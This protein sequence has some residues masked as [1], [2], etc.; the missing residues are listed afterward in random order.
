MSPS[1]RA[2]K[3]AAASSGAP[4]GAYS[5]A[6]PKDGAAGN[7]GQAGAERLIAPGGTGVRTADGTQSSPPR[8]AGGAVAPSWCTTSPRHIGG[9]AGGCIMMDDAPERLAAGAVTAG[10]ATAVLR[11]AAAAAH[12]APAAAASPPQDSGS[13]TGDCA[14]RDGSAGTVLCQS[15]G[16]AALAPAGRGVAAVAATADG[17]RFEMAEAANLHTYALCRVCGVTQG[18]AGAG[19]EAE[20]PRC[21]PTLRPIPTAGS[22]QV[23]ELR[24][25]Q[26][27]AGHRTTHVWVTGAGGAVVVQHSVAADSEERRAGPEA[28]LREQ[29]RLAREATISAAARVRV[30]VTE[31]EAS[32]RTVLAFRG[33]TFRL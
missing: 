20:A 24:P 22:V 21:R 9:A 17:V 10:A 8:V 26:S 25:A 1:P 7:S 12:A 33:K 11:T 27:G 15:S 32:A 4:G 28:L 30:E 31:S 23:H 29:L 6:G 19:P 5:A 16:A 13:S 2:R 3:A 14:A 18:G